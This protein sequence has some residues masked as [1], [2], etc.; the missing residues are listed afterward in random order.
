MRP[1]ILADKSLTGSWRR[2]S[3]EGRNHHHRHHYHHI[4]RIRGYGATNGERDTPG[5]L[6]PLMMDKSCYSGQG[7]IRSRV[8]A[9]SAAFRCVS[10]P[11]SFVQHVGT[12]ITNCKYPLATARW[13]PGSHHPPPTSRLALCL[14]LPEYELGRHTRIES[15]RF[16]VFMR[17][18]GGAGVHFRS[19]SPHPSHSA[20]ARCAK[21]CRIRKCHELESIRPPRASGCSAELSWFPAILPFPSSAAGDSQC[22]PAGINPRVP[23]RYLHTFLPPS[24]F[25]PPSLLLTQHSALV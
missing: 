25:H 16:P 24:I 21:Y 1:I 11:F 3:L 19:A 18:L 13:D 4:H 17:S 9:C 20:L 22:Q 8:S 15:N 10:F 7:I 6:L 23:R 2:T 12:P 14:L 5:N